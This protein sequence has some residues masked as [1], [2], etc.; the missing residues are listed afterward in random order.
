MWIIEKGYCEVYTKCEGT[1]I[2]LERLYTGSVINYR[3]F[4]MRDSMD[5]SIRSGEGTTKLLCMTL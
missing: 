1:E 2:V 3:A 4:F 5:V